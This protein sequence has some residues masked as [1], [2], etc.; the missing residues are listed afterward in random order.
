ML[1]IG[2]K[3]QLAL[4]V[5]ESKTALAMK[6]GSLPVFATPCLAAL[7][8]QTCAE[9]VQPHLEDGRGTVGTVLDIKHLA[10]TPV[11]MRVVCDSELVEIDRRRL[12]FRVEVR[13]EC[14]VVG[15]GRH[16]RF[17]IDSD[18]FLAKAQAKGQG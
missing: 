5:D 15:T 8:E 6:S 11:G 16:E 18:A 2:V 17:V 9:S 3:G 14:E 1:E 13:D 10:A 4:T 7:M 12:V